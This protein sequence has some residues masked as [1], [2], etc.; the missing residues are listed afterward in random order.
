MSICKNELMGFHNFI[1]PE[2]S[3]EE[4]GVLLGICDQTAMNVE[5]SATNKIKSIFMRS[6][7]CDDDDNRLSTT[8]FEFESEKGSEF[9]S[10]R[11]WFSI[12]HAFSVNGGSESLQEMAVVY[13]LLRLQTRNRFRIPLLIRDEFSKCSKSL[14]HI[15]A[16]V[17]YRT[18]VLFH[19]TKLANIIRKNQ[20]LSVNDIT[21]VAIVDNETGED[22][23]GCY[24]L[25]VPM[26]IFIV[27]KI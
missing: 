16:I 15:G 2:L 6:M 11:G 5:K 7:C 20:R 17:K 24:D 26:F 1:K 14:G 18:K 13:C 9:T 21:S 25:P 12:D 10:Q 22:R 4:V 27:N 19:S 8:Q 3:L 23:N